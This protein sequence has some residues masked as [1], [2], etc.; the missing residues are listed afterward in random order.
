M[1]HLQKSDEMIRYEVMK[2]K[3]MWIWNTC[4]CFSEIYKTTMYDDIGCFFAD[5]YADAASKN[6]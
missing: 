5:T 4:R 2:W 6:T 3:S 1:M